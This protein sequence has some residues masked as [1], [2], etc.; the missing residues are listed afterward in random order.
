MQVM[1]ETEVDR[2]L[3]K[4]KITLQE[5][6]LCEK[7]Y[8]DLRRANFSKMPLSKMEPSSGQSDPHASLLTDKMIEV[9]K[10]FSYLDGAVGRRARNLTIDVILDLKPIS[11]ATE[12]ELFRS[13]LLS[14]EY[15]REQRASSRA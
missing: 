4:N 12:L 10:M 6:V 11:S 15:R 8:A 5:H 9:G 3:L 7:I 1:D 13:A 2:L 14:I